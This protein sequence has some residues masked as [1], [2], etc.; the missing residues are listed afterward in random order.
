MYYIWCC[1]IKHRPVGVKLRK[2]RAALGDIVLRTLPASNSPCRRC[3]RRHLREN[4]CDQTV[5]YSIRG[6][7]VCTLRAC[8][9]TRRAVI[10]RSMIIEGV[11]A[12]TVKI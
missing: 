9:G 10:R 4:R 7:A 6:L 12:D 5:I 1:V 2:T 8:L 11:W 3:Q